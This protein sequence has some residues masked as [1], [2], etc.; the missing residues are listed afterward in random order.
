[1]KWARLSVCLCVRLSAIIS[2]ELH[3]LFS[4]NFLCMLPVAVARSSSD[5]LRISGFVDDVIFAHKLI[6]CSTSP[7]GWHSKAH[8]YADLG[9]ARRNELSLQAAHARDYFFQSEPTRPQ[10]ACWIF[11][12]SCSH[13]M[14]LRIQR[15]KRRVIKVTPQVTAP[16]AESV[17]Y[18]C[19]WKLVR[20]RWGTGIFLD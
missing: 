2:S 8:T 1:M 15:Q 19:L 20:S 16:G 11:M 4:Q 6:G 5:M 17:V 9:L 7:P 18:N 14:F 13:V 3:V 10:W 12:T